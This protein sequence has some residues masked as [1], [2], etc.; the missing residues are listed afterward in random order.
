MT[1]RETDVALCRA[2]AGV[3]EMPV[4]F[5]DSVMRRAN[6]K[7][8]ES[9]VRQVVERFE[10]GGMAEVMRD[11]AHATIA[12]AI[13]Y[14]LYTGMLPAD[15]SDEPAMSPEDHFEAVMWRVIQA[16]PPGLSGGYFGHWHYPPE[17]D[18]GRA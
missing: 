13:T 2:L 15:G 5:V 17:D 12:R 14:G 1:A 6:R 9:E 18:D 3:N 4:R 7:F 8:G 11:E 16:H 10:R